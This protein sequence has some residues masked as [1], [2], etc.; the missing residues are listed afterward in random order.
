MPNTSPEKIFEISAITVNILFKFS[1]KE[2]DLA[3]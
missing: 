1:A 3:M 2:S